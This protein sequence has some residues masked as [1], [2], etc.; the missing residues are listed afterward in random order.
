MKT[1]LPISPLVLKS[2][3]VTLSVLFLLLWAASPKVSASTV[4]YHSPSAAI[5]S[6]LLTPNPSCAVENIH[7][8]GNAPATI[9]C[10][11]KKTNASAVSPAITEGCS[12]D[13]SN[14]TVSLD[15]PTYNSYCFYYAGSINL[16]L[17]N[18]W[19]LYSWNYAYG[20]LTTS[21]QPNF[22]F[23]YDCAQY[24][25]W[26]GSSVSSEGCYEL[27]GG[28]NVTV[29]NLTVDSYGSPSILTREEVAKTV[30]T[31]QPGVPAALL[32][33][34]GISNCVRC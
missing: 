11:V 21:N 16:S 30:K 2:T 10:A 3:C 1:R 13:K 19:Y 27:N 8:H 20:R 5:I 34:R 17:K 12:N 18:I 28:V 9:V 23:T 4:V 24:I 6:S 31:A 14:L 32:M 26:C 33:E 29:E 15:T 7:L 25:C 22:Y